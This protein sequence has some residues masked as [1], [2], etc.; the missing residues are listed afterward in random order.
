MAGYRSE[1]VHEEGKMKQRLNQWLASLSFTN[2]AGGGIGLCILG[3]AIWGTV[4][5]LQKGSYS[6]TEWV[7]FTMFGLAQGGVYALI[8]LGYTLIYGVLL[9][10]NFA[11]GEVFMSG[12]YISSFVAVAFAQSGFLYAYPIPAL[13]IVLMVAM[14]TS[15]GVGVAL[16]R[17]AY[18][19]LRRAPRLVPLITA[20]G[21]SFFLQYSFRGLFGSGMKRYPDVP[22]LEG[23]WRWGE[24][25]ILHIHVIVF[26]AAALIMVGLYWFVQ[27]TKMGKAMRAVSEDKSVAALMGIDV[28]QVIVSTFMIGGALAGA[29]GVLYALLFKQVTYGMGFFPG[30]KAFTAAVLGGIGNIPG[31]MFGG[32]F[33]GIFESVGPT[34]FFDGL[35]VPSPGQLKDVIAFIM[36]VLILIFRPTGLF[37]EVLARKKA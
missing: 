5:T 7:S 11:H 21:A 12:T 9:M 4:A 35:G 14:G 31:A 8:A 34:L 16:E 3:V 25:K 32:L 37:G 1:G 36:L 33:L 26:V 22:A 29:A 13:L 23:F 17:I 28:D 18:R 27:R 20:I 6:P 15:V 19:P 24:L 30:I 2:V 10:I